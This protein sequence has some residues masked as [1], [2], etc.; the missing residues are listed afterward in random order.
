M[1]VVLLSE[2]CRMDDMSVKKGLVLPIH[3]RRSVLLWARLRLPDNC[4]RVSETKA[5]CT[6]FDLTKVKV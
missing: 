4:R 3:P 6:K 2:L 5:N 1:R